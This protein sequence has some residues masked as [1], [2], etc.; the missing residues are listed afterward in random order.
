M[1]HRGRD[2]KNGDPVHSSAGRSEMCPLLKAKSGNRTVDLIPS[3]SCAWSHSRHSF[4]FAFT[5]SIILLATCMGNENIR[6]LL[7]L[8]HLPGSIC[9]ARF[10]GCL[11]AELSGCAHTR[12]CGNVFL[13]GE[14][15]SPGH[16]PR[17]VLSTN[18]LRSPDPWNQMV[19]SCEGFRR[20]CHLITDICSSP[21]GS[22]KASFPRNVL[23]STFFRKK[24]F[25]PCRNV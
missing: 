12:T 9:L 24:L 6:N 13:D 15:L 14:S 4:L 10:C 19:L 11:V 7:K 18:Y 2:R 8:A 23:T 25:F 17:F 5:E 21:N 3:I 16:F 22:K 20:V 1:E